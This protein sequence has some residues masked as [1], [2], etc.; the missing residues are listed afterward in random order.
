M[1]TAER[2]FVWHII[3][4]WVAVIIYYALVNV[5][6][7]EA[8]QSCTFAFCCWLPSLRT[9]VPLYL[10]VAVVVWKV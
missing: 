2:E 3:M 8:K 9:V 10:W 6:Y 7:T 1:L 4:S 5:D